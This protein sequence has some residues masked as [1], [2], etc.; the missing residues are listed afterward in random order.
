MAMALSGIGKSYN[1]ATLNKWLT[2][3]NGYKDGYN[4][5]W[6]SVEVLGLKFEGKFGKNKIKEALDN[7]KVVIINTRNKNHWALATSYKNDTILVNDPTY[8]LKSY[9]L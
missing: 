7:D 4:F 2:A 1:P 3:N 8:S 6:N 9:K 5:V